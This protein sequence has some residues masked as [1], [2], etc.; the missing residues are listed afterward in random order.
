MSVKQFT[1]TYSQIED[2]ITFGFNTSE[3]ELYQFLLTRAIAKSFLV[4]SEQI[5]E[6]S[7]G[8][9][10]NER[11]SKLIS[12]FQKEGLKKQLSFDE[13]FDGGEI[14][15]L[16]ND[17]ILISAV[18]LELESEGVR[19]SLT[20]VSN[21]VVG[22]SVP[23]VQLQALT[24]LIEKLAQQALWQITT[25]D[26]ANSSVVPTVLSASSSQLH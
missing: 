11:S 24:L 20:I 5:S 4:Q 9:E 8:A 13:T 18:H 10:H 6:Q 15:P 14:T 25:P 23:V 2:R 3:G 26:D 22:F 21:Q 17:P 1:A 16:G 7:L 19:I 12:E